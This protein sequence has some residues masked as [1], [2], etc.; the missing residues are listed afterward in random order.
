MVLGKGFCQLICKVQ[1]R[2]RIRLISPTDIVPFYVWYR[3]LVSKVLSNGA[4]AAS[5]WTSDD[6]HVAVVMGGQCS[7]YLLDRGSGCVVHG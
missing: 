2:I 7:M 4:L 5:R 6:P 1:M 3:Q